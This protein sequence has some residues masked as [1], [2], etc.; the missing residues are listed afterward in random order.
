MKSLRII[1]S[2]FIKDFFFE[3]KDLKLLRINVFLNLLVAI[4]EL[5]GVGAI[6]FIVSDFFTQNNFFNYFLETENFSFTKN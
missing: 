2:L 5:L 4:L 6:I 3:K 1:I